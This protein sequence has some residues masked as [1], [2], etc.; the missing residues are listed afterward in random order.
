MHK[1]LI[2]VFAVFL[3]IVVGIITPLQA[4][5]ASTST[6][7]ISDLKLSYGHDAAEAKGWLTNQGYTVI[8]TDLNEKADGTFQSKRC[9]YLGY[10]T[11]KKADE[12][13]TDMK[14]MN[15]KGNYSFEAYEMI[16]AEKA[17][18]ISIFVEG[19][20]VLLEEY[21]KN[22]EAGL[23]KAKVAHDML[24]LI[25]DDDTGN[26]LG[27]LLLVPTVQE[28]GDE[29]YSNLTEEDKDHHADMVKILMQGNSSTTLAVEQYLCISADTAEDSFLDRLAAYGCY[30]DFEYDFAKNNNI[31]DAK[32]IESSLSAKYGDVAYY[33]SCGING[34]KEYISIYTDS[35]FF[36]EKD[37]EKVIS[38]FDTEGKPG[39]YISWSNARN[40][41]LALSEYEFE[42]EPLVS[43]LTNED[44][45][46]EDDDRFMLYPLAASLSDG[47]RECS[48]FVSLVQLFNAGVVD[49]EGWARNYDKLKKEVIDTTEQVSAYAGI[50]REIFS[51]NVALT[52]AAKQLN[53]SSTQSY[54]DGFTT[55]TLS[56]TTYL[57]IAGFAVSAL[58]TIGCAV[59]Y[60]ALS[61]KY[62]TAFETGIQKNEM[63]F[64]IAE[65]LITEKSG[66]SL[67]AE[68]VG[69]LLSDSLN[70]SF[71]EQ[72]A[73]E[74]A[75][76]VTAAVNRGHF[77][78][79]C[80]GTVVC[81]IM[82]IMAVFMVV[83]AWKDLKKYYNTE[84]TPIP[85][86]MVDESTDENGIS[87][88][89]YYKAV[90]CNRIEKK[91][92][93]DNNRILKS[94]GDL[95]GDIGKEWVALYFTKDSTAG[96][97]ITVDILTQKGSNQ[98]PTGKTPLTMFGE[99]SA[100]NLVDSRYCFDDAIGGL[101]LF[102]SAAKAPVTSSVM[103]Q[104]TTILSAV[105]AAVIT[106]A[107]S[108]IVARKTKRNKE[109]VK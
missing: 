94:Y 101:Y 62:M 19:L 5:A 53:D 74:E 50:N 69:E 97:P 13:I 63:V 67:E 40:L 70:Q 106:F 34:F 88:Y 4:F 46:F 11:T 58:G 84:K 8:D 59:A 95:N 44:Y 109:E 98:I 17:E 21:R 100:V 68:G 99:K 25:Y 64:D 22:Y 45:D 14:T 24:N 43:F 48:M 20:L 76:A 60:K 56:H 32:A 72:P 52:N 81:I 27:D 73:L 42:G 3:S 26:D 37:E 66:S 41:Y 12:A 77:V 51:D 30:D 16:L 65:G 91:F 9:V 2:K 71:S 35:E 82:I 39:D 10:K 108:F 61:S 83:S 38:H 107:L 6:T 80:I 55:D 18:E 7:Y 89:T 23:Y 57:F 96:R 49:N 93:T 102:Y 85:A 87:T 29:V 79:Q 31:T 92:V 104:N 103:T 78:L 90:L 105:G 86:Y 28:L 1:N 47:Q 75:Y 36:G 33:I 54:L 15:M